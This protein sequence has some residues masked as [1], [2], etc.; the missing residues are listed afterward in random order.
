MNFYYKSAINYV[1]TI[2]RFIILLYRSRSY[3]FVLLNIGGIV[4]K[5]IIMIAFIVSIKSIVLVYNGE[6]FLYWDSLDWNY[7]KLVSHE[8]LTIVIA[9]IVFILFILSGLFPLIYSIG[10]TKYS[11]EESLHF[12]K[13]SAD[14]FFLKHMQTPDEEKKEELRGFL[15]TTDPNFNN[16]SKKAINF[17]F[18]SIQCASVIL[19]SLAAIGYFMPIMVPILLF[20][21]GVIIPLV[22]WKS[23]HHVNKM[24]L[25]GIELKES[26][27]KSKQEILNHESARD[28]DDSFLS[29]FYSKYGSV[30]EQALDFHGKSGER[31]VRF[32]KVMIQSVLGVF[33]ALSIIFAQKNGKNLDLSDMLIIFLIVRFM[34]G[35]LQNLLAGIRHLN[36]EHKTI[37]SIIG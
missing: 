1:K 13:K 29:I 30:E 12:R 31:D 36:A 11:Y 17:L 6:L 21:L 32:I 33:F 14:S 4:S 20:I 5:V 23:Y 18:E 27:R 37:K 9:S 35:T 26:V 8:A 10:M 15:F 3:S 25:R 7:A 22:L 34:F 24:A 28:I 16:S 19:A 2:L